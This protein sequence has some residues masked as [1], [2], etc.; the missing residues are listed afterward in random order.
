MNETDTPPVINQDILFS[1]CFEAVHFVLHGIDI[2]HWLDKKQSVVNNCNAIDNHSGQK[3]ILKPKPI[4]LDS[5]SDIV[6]L[7]VLI[8]KLPSFCMQIYSIC[9]LTVW[10]IRSIADQYCL[11][12]AWLVGIPSNDLVLVHWPLF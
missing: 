8:E 10:Q 11:V 5:G 3:K 2:N 12:W 6:I 4:L 1:I 7:R 9:T